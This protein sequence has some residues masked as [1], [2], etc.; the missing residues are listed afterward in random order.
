[1]LIGAGKC[2]TSTICSHLGNHPDVYMVEPKE[3]HFFSRDEVFARG[4]DWYESLYSEVTNETM[5][6]EG[7]NTYT[8]K[9]AFPHTLERLVQY[10]PTLKLIYCVR[11]P[12]PRIESFWMERRSHGGESVHYDFNRAVKENRDVLVDA[13]NYWQ[14]ILPYFD[15]YSRDNV[16]IIFFEDFRNDPKSV[17][18]A[19]FEFLGV[20]PT[21]PLTDASL[22]TGQTANRS[23]ARPSLS[24]LRSIGAFRAAAKLVPTGVREPIKQRFLFKNMETRPQWNPTV[25]QWVRQELAADTRR[26]LEYCGKPQDFWP[27]D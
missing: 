27:L 5:I 8:A 23:A 19:C 3:P 16:H 7:S 22:H 21:I 10:A 15:A 24:K 25:K 12:I 1:M 4:F 26:L 17:M 18:S 13:S 2:A 9:E 6:G 20:D 14:Q 11:D